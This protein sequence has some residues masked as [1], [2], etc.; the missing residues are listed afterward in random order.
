MILESSCLK[1][2]TISWNQEIKFDVQQG[3]F[4]LAIDLYVSVEISVRSKELLL[5]DNFKFALDDNSFSIGMK[6]ALIK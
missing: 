1:W 3:F 2:H 5:I 6:Q 4:S